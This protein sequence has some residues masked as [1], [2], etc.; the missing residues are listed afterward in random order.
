MSVF[1]GRRYSFCFPLVGNIRNGA[2]LQ[3]FPSE[4]MEFIQ[5]ANDEIGRSP[6]GRKAIH[7]HADRRLRGKQRF[8][9]DKTA[10]EFFGQNL[11]NHAGERRAFL[12]FP[13]M[14]GTAAIEFVV[15][16]VVRPDS[17]A[18]RLQNV[19]VKNVETKAQQDIQLLGTNVL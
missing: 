5:F 10:V 16:M 11:K 1:F 17:M 9:E 13:K 3:I 6:I 18:R 19:A 4:L 14:R 7:R 15:A 8:A 2:V 12:Q